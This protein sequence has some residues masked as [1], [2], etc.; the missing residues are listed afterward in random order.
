MPFLQCEKRA[1]PLSPKCQNN[2]ARHPPEPL[3]KCR[4]M[5][6]L[7][8]ADEF[9]ELVMSEDRTRR[10]KSNHETCLAGRQ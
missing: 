9:V 5:S 4:A 3:R 8:T 10:S 6:N 7:K 2:Q 1:L